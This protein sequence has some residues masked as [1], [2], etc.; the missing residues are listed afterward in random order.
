MV[1][2]IAIWFGLQLPLAIVVGKF[3]KVISEPG[4]SA[5]GMQAISIDDRNLLK[6]A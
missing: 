4:L 5:A 3:L 1:T 6:A 2:A